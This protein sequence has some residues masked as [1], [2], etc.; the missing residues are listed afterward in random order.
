MF[1][2]VCVQEREDVKQGIVAYCCEESRGDHLLSIR[3]VGS[4]TNS[5]L[6]Q[7]PCA[8][9]PCAACFSYHCHY[10]THT[11]TTAPKEMLTETVS[12]KPRLALL[13]L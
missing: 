12:V 7:S 5:A 13:R 4:K 3:S 8:G 2:R 11:N 10:V 9:S 1:V 6:L